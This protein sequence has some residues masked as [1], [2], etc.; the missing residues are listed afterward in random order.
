M[1]PFHL[2]PVIPGYPEI[3]VV[4]SAGELTE[5]CDV[6]V[7]ACTYWNNRMFCKALGRTLKTSELYW[8]YPKSSVGILYVNSRVL[9]GVANT[10]K[11]C[12][13]IFPTFPEDKDILAVKCPFRAYQIKPVAQFPQPV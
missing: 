2:I 7:L 8:Y 12:E 9:P 4:L 13:V 11:Q 6:R 5:L 10:I 1:L 3:K